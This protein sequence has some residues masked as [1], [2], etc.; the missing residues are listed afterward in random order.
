M[1]EQNIQVARRTVE[2]FNSDDRRQAISN[3]H[4]DVEFTSGFTERKTCLGLDGMTEYAD[5][6]DAVWENWHSECGPRSRGAAGVTMSLE[7]VEIV[8]D[9]L[10]ALADG[11]LDAL[12]EF[13][14]PDINWGAIEG[15][16][17][18]VGEM[19]GREA[20]R[21]YVQDWFDTFDNFTAVTE[22]LLDVGDDRVVA[23]QRVTGRARL[24]GVETELRYAVV[25]TPHEGKIMRVREYGHREQALKAVGLAG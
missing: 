5:D 11:G 8:R 7:N 12:A 6:L 10:E 24:S 25:Y 20:A 4:P 1:S 16:P 17:D 19:H 3:F 9:S 22:E 15:A 18:D 14:N 2:V 13:W 23:V 21:R